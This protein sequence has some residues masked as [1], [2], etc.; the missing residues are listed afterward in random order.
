MKKKSILIVLLLSLVMLLPVK[1]FAK[2]YYNDY[3][4]KDLKETLEAEGMELKNKDYK[5]TK[6][7]ATIYLFRGQGCGFC[8]NFLTFINSISEEYGKYFKLV[9]FEVWNDSKNAALMDEVSKVTGQAA[10][11]VPYIIIGETVF[12]G[13][14][15]D[16]DD[17]IKDAIKKQYDNNKYDVFEEVE[18]A[19]KNA[20]KSQGGGDTTTIVICNT[21][22]T[23]FAAG[24]VILVQMVNH[25][26]LMNAIKESRKSPVEKTFE[27]AV[28]KVNEAAKEV[29][30]T[31]KKI[32]KKG[33]K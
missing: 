6:K 13:Y 22:F 29:K 27:K 24:I 7:Q 8:R 21:L 3:A 30:E 23:A 18:K 14:V 26:K 31:T 4:H 9:S 20:N 2:T 17:Q 11:G 28:E 16:W 1:T 15:S 32:V 10:G 33:R 12:P 5:E 25:N 19:A